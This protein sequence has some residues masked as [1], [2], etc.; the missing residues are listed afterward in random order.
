MEFW[1]EN[2]GNR[3]RFVLIPRSN[4]HP[5]VE[6][7]ELVV[8]TTCTT[9]LEAALLD[10][11]VVNVVPIPHPA[12]DYITN[13]V[14]PCF[15]DWREAARAMEAF[16]AGRPGPLTDSRERFVEALEAHFPG[17]RE[18]EATKK[19]A[20]EIAALLREHGAPPRPDFELKARGAGL[21]SAPRSDVLKDKFT[22]TT[23][24]FM[25]RT[26]AAVTLMNLPL[27]L[28]VSV[29]DD[30]LFYIRPV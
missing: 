29:L 13:Y 15:K 23:E 9:G 26:Q 18:G 14:N 25:E 8:H 3:Y 20:D 10:K 30:S 5:W 12:F 27:K 1:Q 28:K 16:A 2:F 19:I 11:P 4:P 24:E 22:L 6:A 17:H 7:S 21:S